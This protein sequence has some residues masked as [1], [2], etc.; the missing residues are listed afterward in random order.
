MHAI[1]GERYTAKLRGILGPDKRD[2]REISLLNRIVRWGTHG[3]EYE[4]DPRHHEIIIEQLGLHSAKPVS[5]PGVKD[6]SEELSDPLNEADATLYRSMVA[7]VNYLAQD[8]PDLSFASKELSRHMSAPA[9]KDWNNLK[10]LGR[11]LKECPRV[12]QVFHWQKRIGCVHA[13]ADSDWAGCLDTRR[14]T[15]GGLVRLGKHEIKHWSTTQ[16]TIALSSAEAEYASLV[17]A[18][19][20]LLGV[21]ALLRDLGVEDAALE[22]HCDSAAAIGIANRTGLGKL[23][24]LQVHLLWVQEH[25]RNKTFTLSKVLGSENPSDLLTK[26]VAQDVMW[27]HMCELN[28]DRRD[29]RA[30]SAPAML[31]S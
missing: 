24:H 28:M 26:H 12:V 22:L 6:T 17:K 8:R 1:L 30:V 19:S 5:T 9:E 13:Y 27:K 4:A 11:Y 25:V 3:I 2:L 16:A 29:G 14:S 31:G 7:R 21:R 10:R 18:A 23:R 15:S 20:Q